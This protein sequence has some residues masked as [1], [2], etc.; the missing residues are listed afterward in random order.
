L[1]IALGFFVKGN[2]FYHGVSQICQEYV[3]LE[4]FVQDAKDYLILTIQS[5]KKLMELIGGQVLLWFYNY[6]FLKLYYQKLVSKKSLNL[7]YLDL[8]L[9]NRA[10]LDLNLFLQMWLKG[11]IPNELNENY[12]IKKKYNIILIDNFCYFNL[13]IK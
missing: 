2:L 12:K 9:R 7:K 6:A 13:T 4:F 3:R 1:G 8:K 11:D 5:I 10:R